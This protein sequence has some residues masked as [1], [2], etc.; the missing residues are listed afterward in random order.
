VP[1]ADRVAGLL[2]LLY[3]QTV[4]DISRLTLD[5]VT[6]DG[7]RTSIRFGV[8]PIDLPEPL[9]TLVRLLTDARPVAGSAGSAWL[10]P[11][12]PPTGP[13]TPASLLK[14]LARVGIQAKP[15]RT[16]ALIQL[17]AELPASVLARSLGISVRTA[18]NW[19]HASSGDWVAYAAD[20]GQRHP[21]QRS[22]TGSQT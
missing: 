17:A 11:G 9:A 6:T 3:A 13:I 21:S 10:F 2:L 15:A 16:A 18:V 22:P 20:I 14:R 5:H 8:R 19:Q 4:G 7:Q 12:R 1:I